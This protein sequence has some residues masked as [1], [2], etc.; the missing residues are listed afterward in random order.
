MWERPRATRSPCRG[1]PHLD[2]PDRHDAAR[3]TRFWVELVVPGACRTIT[4]VAED[5]QF[6]AFTGAGDEINWLDR[7]AT[8]RLLIA[9]A[10][11]NVSDG[12]ARTQLGR[13][14]QRLPDLQE[15]LIELGYQIA[16]DAVHAHRTVRH[17]S[18]IARRGLSARLLPPPDLLGVYVY[19]PDGRRHD[20]Y[21]AFGL[22]GGPHGWRRSARRCPRAGSR[23]RDARPERTY[24]RQSPREEG[25]WRSHRYLPTSA[26]EATK[27]PTEFGPY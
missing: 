24:P 2:S 9:E 7:H 8:D 27:L 3:G 25:L 12:L 19:L 22:S 5:A 1:H 18:R 20:P 4:Q 23:S 6:L 14:L 15:H 11:S 16:A 17:S 26:D 13:A 10:T 21:A